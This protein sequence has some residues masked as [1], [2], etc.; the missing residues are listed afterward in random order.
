MA[1][2][3]QEISR[4]QNN[5]F[6][7]LPTLCLTR[8]RN[9]SLLWW[10]QSLQS[11][12][13]K[14]GRDSINPLAVEVPQLASAGGFHYQRFRTPRPRLPAIPYSSKQPHSLH[15]APHCVEISLPNILSEILGCV[16]PCIPDVG[17]KNTHER[18]LLSSGK[19]TPGQAC[20]EGNAGGAYIDIRHCGACGAPTTRVLCFLPESCAFARCAP[21]A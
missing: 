16:R 13:N 18:K 11:D 15:L 2:P 8:K 7:R 12:A 14:D 9:S 20:Q 21:D 6:A 5:G 1:R 3:R 10:R 17:A 19:E 4:Y